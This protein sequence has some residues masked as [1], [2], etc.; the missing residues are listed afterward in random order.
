MIVVT[1]IPASGKSTVAAVL[2][3]RCA[4]G[5]IVDGDTIRAMVV[6]GC[7]DMSREPSAEAL[8]QLR[9]RYQASL[10]VAGVYLQ[11][12]FD[13]VFNDNVLGPLLDELPGLV[14]CD[15]FHLVVLNPSP[16]VIRDRD[17][18]RA[19]TAYTA[20]NGKFDWLRDVLTKE[21]PRL[22]LW[23]DTSRQ[24]PDESADI[25]IA[26]LDESL[27]FTDPRDGI[28]SFMGFTG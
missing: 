18:Q 12:G 21:T 15:R 1:G 14:P 7:V 9:L 16:E 3:Q 5:V 25:I 17:R 6:S 2:A 11:A 10:A 24:T 26:K 13:V 23:L 20:E 4:R 22:G 8:W 28:T 27:I 19:K